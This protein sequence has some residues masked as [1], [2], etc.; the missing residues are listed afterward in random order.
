M[1]RYFE[2]IQR[3]LQARDAAQQ[4][5]LARAATGH[6][7]NGKFAKKAPEPTAEADGASVESPLERVP[8]ETPAVDQPEHQPLATPLA[9]PEPRKRTEDSGQRASQEE[10][11]PPPPKQPLDPGLSGA[12]FFAWA[13]SQRRQ[14]GIIGEEPPDVRKL[15]DW[16]SVAMMEV[17]GDVKR[18]Q[19]AYGHFTDS[20]FWAKAK[21]P[22]HAFLSQWRDHVPNAQPRPSP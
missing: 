4:G 18:L 13:Q 1:S 20:Q 19:Y 9:S 5:G 12:G 15:S 11:A 10:E 14:H 6:R 21:W 8:A 22:F 7:I 2:P 16:F 17:N 3:R